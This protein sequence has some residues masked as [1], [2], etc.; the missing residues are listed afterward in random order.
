MMD[1]GDGRGDTIN[2]RSTRTPVLDLG[3][4]GAGLDDVGVRDDL[5]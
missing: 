2:S 1:E 5:G 4:D 3:P